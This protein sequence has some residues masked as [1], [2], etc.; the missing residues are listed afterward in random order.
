MHDWS[1]GGKVA[2]RFRRVDTSTWADASDAGPLLSAS[3][4]RV[5]GGL[6]ESGSAEVARAVGEG[7][8]PGYYRLSAVAEGRGLAR[9]DVATLYFAGG[10]SSVARGS[11]TVGIEGRSVL[12]PAS[13]RRMLAGSY[14]P[15]GTDGAAA[16]ARLLRECVACPVEVEGAF[17][18][19]VPVIFDLGCSYLDAVWMLLDAGGW[20]MQVSGRGAV[21]VK[22]KPTAPSS[23]LDA[24]AARA[25][26]PGVT[27][28]LDYSGVPN[29]YLA[30]DGR[31]SVRVVND[32]PESPTSTTS[33]GYVHDVVDTAPKPVDGE[34][35]A[36]YAR[37]KLREMSTVEDVRGY[38]RAYEPDLR[39]YDVVR[40]SLPSQGL[41][42]DMRITRQSLRIG[43]GI[44]V[45]EEACKE[46]TTWTA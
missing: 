44:T 36:A 42:G 27:S 41:S 3:V 6:L 39:P 30:D 19:N 1:A 15:E 17:T 40:F 12:Y 46:V 10:S 16:A 37:R 33:R 21:S 11:K 7:F 26:A 35:L 28:S 13:V 38:T 2:F 32:D 20:C 29:A 24:S 9:S 8:E 4:E 45:T 14:A 23:L 34:T 25:L 31:Q 5:R 22:P 18:L 43:R